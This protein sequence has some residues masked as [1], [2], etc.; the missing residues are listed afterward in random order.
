[1]DAVQLLI[2][3]VLIGMSNWKP[4]GAN[5]R[6][7]ATWHQF[8][9]SL[10]ELMRRR[11]RPN[12]RQLNSSLYANYMQISGRFDRR[13]G[14]H[15]RLSLPPPLPQTA[16]AATFQLMAINLHVCKLGR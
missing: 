5:Y 15:R 4:P 14:R 3:G 11:R 8:N 9:F 6:N 7:A 12:R 10:A 16:T 13:L 1:M 2:N